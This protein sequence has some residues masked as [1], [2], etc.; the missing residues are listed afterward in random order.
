MSLTL[1]LN[2]SSVGCSTQGF[3][4]TRHCLSLSQHFLTFLDLQR[5]AHTI[6][7]CSSGCTWLICRHSFLPWTAKLTKQGSPGRPDVLS[8]IPNSRVL[9]LLKS[10]AA[11]TFLQVSGRP[12]GL[13]TSR[14]FLVKAQWMDAKDQSSTEVPHH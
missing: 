11:F 4:R 8:S 14:P 3:R 7:G 13:L 6:Q 9:A 1:F 5:T 12:F 10:N 2:S